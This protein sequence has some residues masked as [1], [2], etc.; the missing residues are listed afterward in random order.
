MCHGMLA[1]IPFIR[2]DIR[3]Q[4]E[5]DWKESTEGGKL[6]AIDGTLPA[7]YLLTQLRTGHLLTVH[8][9]EGIS[10]QDNDL[11]IYGDRETLEHV[12]WDCP[13]LRGLQRE[14]RGKVGDV[15]N[16]VS[17]LLEGFRE[18]M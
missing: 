4:L 12:L 13:G 9:C 16:S 5:N 6:R 8:K 1:R 17:R 11:C 10:L 2:E 3:A 14:L 18:E 15:F 7:K